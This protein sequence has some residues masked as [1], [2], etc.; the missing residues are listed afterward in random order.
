MNQQGRDAGNV[1]RS[2]RALQGIAQQRRSESGL[3]MVLVYGQPPERHHRD[4]VRTVSANR[5][6]GVGVIERTP[7]ITQTRLVSIRHR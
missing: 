5:A 7:G 1:G 4:R 2:K 3:L 6:R